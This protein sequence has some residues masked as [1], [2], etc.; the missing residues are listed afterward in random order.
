MCWKD[1]V[2]DGKATML[3]PFAPGPDQAF[4]PGAGRPTA[5]MFFAAP[6]RSGTRPAEGVLAFRVPI[7]ADFTRILSIARLG[8]TGE[9]YAFDHD[10]RLLSESRF[11]GDLRKAGL[12]AEGVKSTLNVEIRD[13]G[14]NTLEGYQPEMPLRA[15]PLTKMAGRAITGEGGI[16]IDG[17]RDYRGVPVVGAWEW[18]PDLEF[19]VTHEVDVAE[20]YHELNLLRWAFWLLF[21]AAAFTGLLLSLGSVAMNRLHRTVR[22]AKQL[23]QYTLV[24]KIGEG[25]MGKVYRASHAM[26]RRPTAL[27]L[28][29]TREP[30]ALERF[31]REVQL[32]SQLSHPNTIAIYDYGRTPE[33]IFYYAME[34]L[35]GIDLSDLIR[36]E[37]PVPPARVVHILRQVCG[38]L[39]EAHGQGFIHRDI[40][41]SNIMLTNRGGETDIVKVLDFGLVKSVARQPSTLLTTMGVVFGTPGFIPPETLKDPNVFDARGDLYALGAVAYELITGLSVFEHTTVFE[42][43]RKHVESDPDLPSIRMSRPVPPILQAVIMS[44]LSKAPE[45]RPQSAAELREMLDACEDVGPWTRAESRDWWTTRREAIASIRTRAPAGPDSTANTVPVG[46][47]QE[48]PAKAGGPAA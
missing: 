6:L 45:D 44:C 34:Y 26:L 40:K 42:V 39:A 47:K 5:V 29:E 10:G 24:E 11:E 12:L 36:L 25:A 18:F 9:T 41:P 33:G 19:G 32:T 17:Y 28:L 8:D 37:G 1:E 21:G 38:S 16:D 14:G 3:P 7:A 35:E 20:A 31:E 15:R 13:P 23:G 30:G 22:H 2:M 48:M 46:Q 4:V 43:C 27:K